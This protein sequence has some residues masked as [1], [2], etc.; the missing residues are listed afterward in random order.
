MPIPSESQFRPQPQD[1]EARM[2]QLGL[3]PREREVCALL[4]GA[5]SLKQVAFELQISYGTA[6]KHNTNI[7][8]KLGIN[9]KAELFHI[10]GVISPTAGK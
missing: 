1:I 9:S 10:F 7:Y 4:L 6:N 3:T 8:R 2:E 5:Y